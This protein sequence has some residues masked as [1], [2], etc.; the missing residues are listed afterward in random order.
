[1]YILSQIFVVLSDLLYVVSMQAKKKSLLV[2][3]LFVSD[4]LYGLQYL[5]LGGITGA[6]VIFI[7]SVYLVVIY[8]LERYNKTK[9]NLIPTLTAIL[10]TI[11]CSIIT[12][13]G[14]ISL[15]PMI[16]MVVSFA[17]MNDKN[18]I[19]VKSGALIRNVLNLVYMII[20][21]SIFGAIGQ[22]ALMI[23]TTIGIIISVKQHKLNN[24]TNTTKAD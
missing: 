12:W 5:F 8:L 20:L 22:V 6:I 21:A 10:L 2:F 24:A 19:I 1:M 11:V 9:Y 13:E 7:D 4:V 3:I 15:I 17:S 14:V 16:A 18:I 23:A